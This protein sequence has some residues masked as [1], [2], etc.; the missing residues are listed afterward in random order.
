M[1]KKDLQESIEFSGFYHV[2]GMETVLIS[3]EGKVIDLDGLYCPIEQGKPVPIYVTD[4]TTKITEWW[5]SVEAFAKSVGSVKNTI[6]KSMLI[7]TGWWKHYQIK[8]CKS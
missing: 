2:P 6:Q 3:K 8:Y 1:L 7:K 5:E 4:A